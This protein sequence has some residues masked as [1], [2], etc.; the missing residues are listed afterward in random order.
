M[1]IIMVRHGETIANNEKRYLGLKNSPYTEKGKSQVE[2]I[3]TKLS[4]YRNIKEI[5]CS[6][7]PRTLSIADKIATRLDKK[8][9]ITTDI[10]ELDFGIFDGKTYKEIE[11]DHPKEWAAWVLDQLNYK[12][13]KGESMK[14]LYDRVSRFIDELIEKKSEGQYLL[15]THGG[16]IQTI[17]T[18]L[19]DLDIK[20]RWHFK[21]P[22]GAIVE[23]DYRENYGVLTKLE[24]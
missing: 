6:Q 17:I 9:I 24:Y 1:K 10:C 13:P 20:D 11:K 19:L 15:I 16:I 3:V 22:P 7:L 14:D 23:I 12:I 21:I 8:V 18:Y 5:Y 2:E 4:K